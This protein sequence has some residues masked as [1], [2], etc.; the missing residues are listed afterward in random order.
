MIKKGEKEGEKACECSGGQLYSSTLKMK[1]R[2]DRE[3][4]NM[5]LKNLNLNSGHG[6]ILMTHLWKKKKKKKPS[7]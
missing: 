5:L 7:K 3:A 1:F 4:D 6:F 2:Q